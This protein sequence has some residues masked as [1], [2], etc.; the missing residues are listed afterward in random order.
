M[1]S[2]A[3]NKI[4]KKEKLVNDDTLVV[5]VDVSK[6]KNTG[7]CRCADGTETEPFEF[8][9]TRNG[10]DQ[11]YD[12]IEWMKHWKRLSHVVVGFESTGPYAEPLTHFLR[13][14]KVNLVQV[15]AS[16]TKKMKEV[17]DNSPGKTDKKDPK[18]IADLVE[19]GRVLRVVVPEGIAAELRRLV[20]A[21]ERCL[22]N[23]NSLV[24]Q[25]YDLVFVI[26]PEFGQI[27]KSLQTKTAQ[28]LLHHYATPQQVV[29]L[30]VD[31]LEALM[32]T[33]SRGRFKRDKAQC[34]FEAAQ[35]TVGIQEGQS[36]I[37]KEIKNILQA[38]K[39]QLGFIDELEVDISEN[40][41]KICRSRYLLSIKGIGEITVAV[42]IGEVA[43]FDNF[44][45]NREMEKFAGLN[46]FEISSGKHKGQRRISKR[47]RWLLRKSLYFASLNVVRKD[48]V[49]HDKYQT[50][51][52]RGMPR[53]KAL[54]AIARKLLR[55]MFALVRDH[56][57]FDENYLPNNQILKAA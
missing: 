10:F 40:L 5:T 57:E 6:G 38:I 17:Y 12:K 41:A 43:D 54:V 1:R 29:K 51:L 44:Q 47:G 35:Q 56:N 50:L 55:V 4:R 21:R 20:H 25:L 24:N 3:M 42:V 19:L 37:V 52:A 8:G 32:R 31:R 14:K 23:K 11:F 7:Y 33:L 49:F 48:G 53:K 15:N 36:S 45:T 28:H 22:Q 46:L 27:I 18:V 26:F 9:N 39:Q 34:L 30:G 2:I 16:H 13:S